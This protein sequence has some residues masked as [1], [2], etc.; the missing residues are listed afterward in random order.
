MKTAV[1]G[2]TG[3]IGSGLVRLLMEKGHTVTVLSRSATRAAASFGG[4]VRT[5]EWNAENK[6][7]LAGELNGVDAIV[8][9]AGENIGSSLWT[10]KKKARILGSRLAAG[11]LV[12]EVIGSM[13]RKPA[14]LVQASAVGYYGN[15]EEEALD[16][17]S[18]AGEDFLADVVKKW[19]DS[20]NEVESMGVRRIIIRTG[21]VFA[22]EGGA[23]PKL[24]MPYKFL[25]GTVPG[26][27][28]QWVPW[29]DYSDEIGAIHFLLTKEFAAGIYNL[30]SPNPARMEDICHTMSVTLQRPTII[31]IPGLLLKILMGK[32]AEETIL[33]SQKVL[34]TRLASAGYPFKHAGLKKSISSILLGEEDL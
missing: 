34:P 12:T 22:S 11:R 26:S 2:A 10:R 25:F 21:V 29:I 27:G 24:A 5:L 31:K 4:G 7:A 6:V 13:K 20:T 1:I 32:M 15:R 8:N 28:K 33:T 9:L 16:E 23:F 3:F 14:T 30:V 19:E 17:N 18:T